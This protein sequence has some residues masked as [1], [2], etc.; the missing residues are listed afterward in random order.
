MSAEA[1]RAELLR[2]FRIG[3]DDLAANRGGRLGGRQLARIRRQEWATAALVLAGLAVLAG[4]LWSVA[5]RPFNAAQLITAGLVAAGL[6]AAGVAHIRRLRRAT[7]EGEGERESEVA[8]HVGPVK[9]GLRGRAGWWLSINGQSFHLPVRFWHIGPGLEYRVYVATSANL[10]VAMEPVV[11]LTAETLA[12]ERTD[13]GEFPFAAVY[14]GQQLRIRVND[15]PAEP[16]YTLIA[17][18]REAVDLDDWPAA[19]SRPKP[20][21]DLLRIAGAEQARRGRVD[22]I[23][24]ADRAYRLCTGETDADQEEFTGG[25]SRA[26]LDELLG[27]GREGVRIHWDSARP[28]HYEVETGESPYVCTVTAYFRGSETA[29]ERVLL[30]RRSR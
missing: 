7:A 28:M 5:A 15:F 2:A 9:V 11:D 17:D 13:D 23:F 22:A 8:C 20:T 19:W 3:P 26:A 14:D 30:Q 21:P 27:P 16:L 6:L 18:G 29:A 4:I 10:I 1:H 12:W 24:V 25:P